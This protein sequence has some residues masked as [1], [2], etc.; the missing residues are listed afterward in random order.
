M[1][2]TDAGALADLRQSCRMP[3]AGLETIHG[4]SAL[5]P[6]LSARCADVVIIDVQW[7]GMME[8]MR[9]AQLADAH[10]LNVASHNYHGHLSTL[11][12]AHFSAA[13]SNFQIMEFEV[14][15]PP[16]LA[17]LLT[18]PLKIETGELILPEGLGW[19]SDID[20][21]AVRAHPPRS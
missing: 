1:D 6:Y 20:E 14:D 9:M 18:H 16:W 12:G 5:L 21:A 13:I 7:Q 17:M 19:G 4:A 2:V 3:I 11:M 8:A 10:E 15:E